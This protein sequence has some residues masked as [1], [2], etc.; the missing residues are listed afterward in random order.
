M[1]CL[2]CYS[3]KRKLIT[4][5]NQFVIAKQSYRLTEKC[6][7]CARSYSLVTGLILFTKRR[8]LCCQWKKK[9]VVLRVVDVE[10]VEHQGQVR[11]LLLTKEGTVFKLKRSKPKKYCKTWTISLKNL[12]YTCKLEKKMY[13]LFIYVFVNCSRSQVALNHSSIFC[14]K[15]YTFSHSLNPLFFPMIT[16]TLYNNSS[17]I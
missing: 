13:K 11:K 16:S 9:R 8:C 14:W 5:E 12:V 15:V 17:P 1:L 6:F 3:Y 4:R 10:S 2:V 7:P